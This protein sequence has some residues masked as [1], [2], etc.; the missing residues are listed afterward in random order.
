MNIELMCRHIPLRFLHDVW[1]DSRIKDKRIFLKNLF[2]LTKNTLIKL[3]EDSMNSNFSML[4]INYNLNN[5]F[6]SN[7]EMNIHL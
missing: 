6:E 7:I 3:G 4:V 2:G 1:S 5:E